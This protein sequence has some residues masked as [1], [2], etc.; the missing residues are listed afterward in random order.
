MRTQAQIEA[1]RRNGGKSNGPKTDEGRTRSSQNA[2]K[3][4]LSAHKVVVLEGESEDGW[5]EFHQGYIAK[6]QPR[7]TVED[8][9]VLEMA[10]N[11]WRLQ[12]AWAMETSTV[13]I[14]A[15]DQREIVDEQYN[16]WDEVQVHSRSYAVRRA[17]LQSLGQYESR[18]ARNFDRALKQ[19]NAIRA[20][21]FSENEPK[22]SPHRGRVRQEQVQ[23]AQV[24]TTQLQC[25][26]VS[27]ITPDQV[28]GE[29]HT[30]AGA[31]DN[32][33]QM[34][35]TE[36][37]G[38]GKGSAIPVSEELLRT[39]PESKHHGQARHPGPL[40]PQVQNEVG[41]GIGFDS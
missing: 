9:L 24:V 36:P 8:H 20:K 39:G 16:N 19:Y 1:S 32:I 23:P 15:I 27:E 10:V 6:F 3:H 41:Q 30:R 31:R 11:R 21:S 22:P 28:L 5:A 2:I 18:L 34:P 7:D 12:R 35:H 4:G 33:V 13:D 25:E 40:L 29:P 26:I 14:A 37:A 38:I 17:S